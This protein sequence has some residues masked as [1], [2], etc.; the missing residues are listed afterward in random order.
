MSALDFI[1][2]FSIRLTIGLSWLKYSGSHNSVVRKTK[3]KNKGQYTH[4][5]PQPPVSS[6][7]L[8]LHP[9]LMV[10]ALWRQT[11]TSGPWNAYPSTERSSIYL[12]WSLV[13]KYY[14]CHVR[15]SI[16]MVYHLRPDLKKLSV[17][18]SFMCGWRQ[19]DSQPD[20]SFT[21]TIHP[22]PLAN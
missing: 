7:L 12:H 2:V 20:S 13:W 6:C 9:L 21:W 4:S 8:S 14:R 3:W 17:F 5:F 15:S 11:E 22:L 19:W 10:Q 1:F 18:N 16:F